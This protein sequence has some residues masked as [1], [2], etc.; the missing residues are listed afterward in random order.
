VTVVAAD[1]H[2]VYDS[3][4]RPENYI[5]DYNMRFSRNTASDLNEHDTKSLWDVQNDLMGFKNADTILVGRGLET[6]IH[7]L[8]I[9]HGN[10]VHT[11]V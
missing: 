6:D 4:V 8:P 1:G 3:L 5:I 9:I 7:V 10:V 2:L 11:S